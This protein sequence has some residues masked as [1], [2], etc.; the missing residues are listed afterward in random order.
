MKKESKKNH[1]D[2][3]QNEKT[4]YIIVNYEEFE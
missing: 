3:L 2:S 1:N 4:S